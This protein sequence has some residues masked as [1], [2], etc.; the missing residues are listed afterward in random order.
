[1]QMLEKGHQFV[2]AEKDMQ[3]L[4]FTSYELNYNTA[5]QFMIHKIYFL[6]QSQGFVIETF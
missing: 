6:P 4:G 3:P 1:M 2:L 5:P